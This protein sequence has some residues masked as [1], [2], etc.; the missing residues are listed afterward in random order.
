MGL[1]TSGSKFELRDRII[2]ALD[3]EGKLMPAVKK[4]STSSFNWSK[5]ELHPETVIT[6]NISFGQNLRSF[7]KTHIGPH[8]AFHT[9]FMKWAKENPGKTLS[10][11]VSKWEEME[12]QRK[13]P[14]YRSKIAN[15]NMF[16]QYTRDI[17][18][19]HP[20]LSLDQVRTCWLHK[21]QLPS[22]D[23]FIRYEASDLEFLI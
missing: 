1:P 18:D 5:E 15:H 20:E 13:D 16:N 4:K 23:G 22:D 21:K 17:L 11:A 8:F 7:M 19:A 10:D 6:D 9:G 12:A 3:N 2:Y 14:N